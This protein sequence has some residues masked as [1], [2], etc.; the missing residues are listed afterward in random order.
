MVIKRGGSIGPARYPSETLAGTRRCQEE[1]KD[2][3]GGR[4][5]DEGHE[6]VKRVLLA[7]HRSSRYRE[8]S[9]EQRRLLGSLQRSAVEGN[10][11]AY[12]QLLLRFRFPLK[13]VRQEKLNNLVCVR[14]VDLVKERMT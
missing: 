10:C 6:L 5:E 3:G 11:S 13:K 9:Q 14:G 12:T 8:R 7:P 2:S 1:E 4:A